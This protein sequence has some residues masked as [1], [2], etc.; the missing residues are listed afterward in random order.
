MINK[1]IVYI[2][3]YRISHFWNVPHKEYFAQADTISKGIAF[4]YFDVLTYDDPA[5]ATTIGK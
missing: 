1:W 5:E 4:N 2:R 3:K